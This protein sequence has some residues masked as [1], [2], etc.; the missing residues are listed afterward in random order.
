MKFQTMKQFKESR[1]GKALAKKRQFFFK[2]HSIKGKNMTPARF[3]K[4]DQSQKD[5]YFAISGW[6]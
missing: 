4:L 5:E 1:E 3:S 6:V 2:K